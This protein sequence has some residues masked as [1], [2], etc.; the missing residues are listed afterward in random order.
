[1]S[2]S[3]RFQHTTTSK[4]SICTVLPS[5]ESFMNILVGWKLILSTHLTFASD[6]YTRYVGLSNKVF[7]SCT[8]KKL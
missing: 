8:I 7:I 6:I 2:V 3:N 1:M 5:N 4:P